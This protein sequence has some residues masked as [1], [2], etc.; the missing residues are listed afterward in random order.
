MMRQQRA[1]GYVRLLILLPLA[2]V[3]IETRSLTHS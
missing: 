1:A 2:D 3:P